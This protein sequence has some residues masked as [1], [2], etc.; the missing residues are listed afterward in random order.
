MSRGPGS[1]TPPD[2]SQALPSAALVVD[3]VQQTIGTGPL[4]WGTEDWGT[5]DR[6]RSRGGGGEADE[7]ER[8]ALIYFAG[9]KP[10]GFQLRLVAVKP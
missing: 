2:I 6:N 8:P 10:R 9:Q 5:E 3:A 4:L 1:G 7:G